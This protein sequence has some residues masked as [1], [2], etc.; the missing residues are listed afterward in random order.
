VRLVCGAFVGIHQALP[1]G[2][3]DWPAYVSHVRG[4]IIESIDVCR[5]EEYT[6][7]IS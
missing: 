2:A 4:S 1:D 7:L 3:N 5:Q 6:Y